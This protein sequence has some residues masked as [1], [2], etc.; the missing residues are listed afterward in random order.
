MFDARDDISKLSYH[1]TKYDE[2]NI[3][4]TCVSEAITHLRMLLLKCVQTSNA[5]HF[6]VCARAYP[7]SVESLHIQSVDVL[8]K[9]YGTF[10]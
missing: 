2:Q 8:S 9:P 7:S 10:A 1:C 4:D 3:L 5:H 6:I